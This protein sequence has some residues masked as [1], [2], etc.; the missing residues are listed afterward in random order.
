MR[1]KNILCT[2]LSRTTLMKKM[3]KSS[4]IKYRNEYIFRKVEEEKMEIKKLS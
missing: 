3:K 4:V 1:K 2:N